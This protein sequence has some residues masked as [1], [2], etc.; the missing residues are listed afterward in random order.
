VDKVEDPK[1]VEITWMD[2]HGV[3]STWEF[4]EDMEELKPERIK[5]VGYL[6]ADKKGYKTIVQSVSDSQ[7]LGRLTIPAGCIRRTKDIPQAP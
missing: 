1:L 3:T 6:I 2:S 5:S 4:W 7:V